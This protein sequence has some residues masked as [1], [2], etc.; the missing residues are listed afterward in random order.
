MTD[1]NSA[2]TPDANTISQIDPEYLEHLRETVEGYPEVAA[3]VHRGS[4]ILY[5]LDED[6]DG[7]RRTWIAW[8]HVISHRWAL[9][10][11]PGQGRQRRDR[12]CLW[13]VDRPTCEIASSVLVTRK[14][15]GMI[16]EYGRLSESF[17]DDGGIFE[18]F[19]ERGAGPTAAKRLA[20]ELTKRAPEDAE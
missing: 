4:R 8:H 3:A 13:V 18:V 5:I 19:V 11:V 14:R 10:I 9:D 2:K 16:A 15:S 20:Y 1:E 12:I 6:E 7:E 17:P